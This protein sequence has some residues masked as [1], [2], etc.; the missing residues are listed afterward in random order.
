MLQVDKIVGLGAPADFIEQ[1]I[2]LANAHHENLTVD[3]IRYAY[4]LN[5]RGTCGVFLVSSII[6]L[7]YPLHTGL[8]L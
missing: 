7:V 4:V 8:L 2:E 5:L 6:L 3:I 1:L